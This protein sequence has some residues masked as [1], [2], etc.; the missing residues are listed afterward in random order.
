MLLAAVAAE[1]GYNVIIGEQIEL[2]SKLRFL[3]RG[4]ILEKGATN[5]QVVEILQSRKAGNRV[6]VIMGARTRNLLILEE[7]MRAAA[8]E[9]VV[10]TDDGSYGIHG[11]VT[12]ELKTMLE[13]GE[14]ID[15]ILGVGPVPMMKALCDL[16]RPYGIMT[17][18]SL[19]PIMV[20][21]TG[22]CGACR[23]EVGGERRFV[24]VDG[25][26]FDAHQ[27]DWNLLLERQRFYLEQEKQALELFEQEH[28]CRCAEEK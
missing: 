13:A 9:V 22:M 26:E 12:Q 23:V 17:L 25:P 3:P 2:R 7:E 1:A 8:D 4:I 15:R 27:V 10:C 5:H 19:N 18:V 16:T 11:F 28:A 20:D 6:V 14:K 21:G 24:C